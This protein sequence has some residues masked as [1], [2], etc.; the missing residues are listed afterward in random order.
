MI[1]QRNMN[2]VVENSTPFIPFCDYDV[3]NKFY[4]HLCSFKHINVC[5]GV[6]G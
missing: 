3:K 6:H 1:T 5:G 4:V 2:D